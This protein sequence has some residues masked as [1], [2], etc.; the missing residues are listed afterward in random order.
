[1]ILQLYSLCDGTNKAKSMN[2]ERGADWKTLS[3]PYLHPLHGSFS[4]PDTS[5]SF[6]TERS[7]FQFVTL[8]RC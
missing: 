8:C 5:A 6:Q 1:M 2:T 3:P 7:P 4:P